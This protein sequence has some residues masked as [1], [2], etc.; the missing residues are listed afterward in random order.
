MQGIMLFIM[1]GLV[2]GGTCLVGVSF[3][4]IRRVVQQ[5]PAGNLRQR[6][7]VLSGL[8]LIFVAGYLS[9]AAV[10][11]FRYNGALDL[12]VPLIFFNGAA[13]VALVSSLA[14]QTAKLTKQVAALEYETIIDPLTGVYN[15]RHFDRNME[16]EIERVHRYGLPLSLLSLDI[17]HFKRINDMYGHDIGDLVLKDTGQLILKVV[18]RTDIVA[19]LGGDEFA[20]IAPHTT[21][22]VAMDLAERLR[23]VLEQSHIVPVDN[24]KDRERFTVTASIGVAG[25][26][27]KGVENGKLIKSADEALYRAKQ[28]GRNRVM[29][30]DSTR[31]SPPNPVKLSAI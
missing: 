4:P 28:G 18:R 12:L 6:W 7:H 25:L 10:H 22:S 23:R 13:F 8:I 27:Q 5:L 21:V 19:R 11:G 3:F 31:E 20:I 15:R 2:I 1:N 24:H 30:S 14:L 26:D 17:D 16:E 29:V 9:Y